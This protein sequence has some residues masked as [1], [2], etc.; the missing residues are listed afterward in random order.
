MALKSNKAE[1]WQQSKPIPNAADKTGQPKSKKRASSQYLAER[2]PSC[3]SASLQWLHIE[4]LC[5]F[6]VPCPWTPIRN[7]I[8]AAP[9]H[10]KTFHLKIEHVSPKGMQEI[11]G[12]VNIKM[13]T[14]KHPDLECS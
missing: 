10:S 14:G 6:L 2:N 1:Q 12:S 3:S 4:N 7:S 13:I 11:I 8:A 9:G 5:P